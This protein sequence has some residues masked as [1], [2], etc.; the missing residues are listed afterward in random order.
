MY[1]DVST[2]GVVVGGSVAWIFFVGLVLLPIELLKPVGGSVGRIF[3]SPILIELVSNFSAFEDRSDV[4][5]WVMSKKSD[6][7]VFEDSSKVFA[8]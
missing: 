3:F 8:V 7:G 6:S 2:S 1:S 4:S 5:L